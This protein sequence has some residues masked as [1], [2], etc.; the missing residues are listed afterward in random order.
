MRL[1]PTA[2]TF[3]L[4]A[5]SI[6]GCS[7]EKKEQTQAAASTGAQSEEDKTLY[8]L[9]AA[10]AR[11]IQPFDLTEAELKQVQKGFADAALKKDVGDIQQYFPK[12]QELQEKRIAAA[13]EIE[14][15]S[16]EAFL[17]KAAAEPGAR[18]TPSG[19]VYKEVQAGT[20]PSPAGTDTVKV[21]YHGTLQDGKVFDSSVERNEPATFPLNGVIPCWTEGV[22]MMK[23]GGK[24]R[25][26]CPSAIA[27][28]D[29][30]APPDIKPGATLIFDVELLGIEK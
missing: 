7:G 1:L 19:L 29:R 5:F 26:V 2:V 11:N 30:G 21:H 3:G 18:Q 23:V 9:G 12:I 16:G 28:G 13:A 24:A 14:K 25:I 20:G 4:I 17:A 22:Q 15:K 8:A 10:V 27:Y 6:A